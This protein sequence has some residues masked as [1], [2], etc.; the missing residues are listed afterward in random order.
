M[1]LRN[2]G[3]KKPR[4]TDVRQ[5]CIMPNMRIR[6]TEHEVDAN[7]DRQT[8]RGDHEGPPDVGAQAP[9]LLAEVRA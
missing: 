6:S 2:G 1:P 3:W 9:E 5:S 7:E 4:L 8:D